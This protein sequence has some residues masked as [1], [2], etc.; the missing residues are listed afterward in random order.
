VPA[1]FSLDVLEAAWKRAD[2]KCECVN[3][4]CGHTGRCNRTLV[5]AAKGTDVPGGWDIRAVNPTGPAN[6]KNAILLCRK[7]LK[8]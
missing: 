4:S 3:T 7:C 2:G 8:T 1:Q 6:L 5:K